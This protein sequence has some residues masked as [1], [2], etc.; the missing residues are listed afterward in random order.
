M[1]VILSKVTSKGQATLPADVRRLLRIGLGDRV[2]F[3]VEGNCV[4]IKRA[5]S[6]DI[7]FAAAL[8]STLATEWL[9]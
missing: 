7:E 8:E 9:A 5:T 6:V 1:K 3:K 4:Q 2:A